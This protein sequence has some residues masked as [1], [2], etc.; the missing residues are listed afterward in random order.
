[1]AMINVDPEKQHDAFYRYKMP[2]IQIKVEGNG[3][4][5]KTVICNINGVAERI[6]RLVDYP[7]KFF[8]YELAA[9]SKFK[10]EKWILTGSFN[11]EKIQDCVFD[12]IKRFVLCKSC[13]NPETVIRVD[14]KKNIYLDCKACSRST[15]ISPNEKLC[16]AILKTE[17]PGE[18]KQDKVIAAVEAKEEKEKKRKKKTKDEK[19]AEAFEKGTREAKE[20]DTILTE[21]EERVSP[22]VILKE[23]FESTSPGMDDF[24]GK[25]LDLKEEYGLTEDKFVVALVFEALFDASINEKFAGRSKYI[26]RFVKT[27]LE[28]NVIE[29]LMVLCATEES[30]KSKFPILLKKFYDKDIVSEDS[31]IEWH[32]KKK[33]PKSLDKDTTSYFKKKTQAFVDWLQQSD[34]SSEDDSEDEGPGSPATPATNSSKAAASADDDD[35]S[36]VDIDAI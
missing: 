27:E 2:R 30:I 21:E 11:Q 22:V 35:G 19:E 33:G 14:K 18:E 31:I 20:E 16:N 25:V 1:M 36:D 9:T 8:A 29:A 3:N 34:S 15:D 26:K 13:R 4:G 17:K 24:V 12:F 28:R 10:D 32:E 23:F 6:A 5:I 7:M